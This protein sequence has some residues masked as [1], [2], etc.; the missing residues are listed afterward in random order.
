MDIKGKLVEPHNAANTVEQQRTSGERRR[1]RVKGDAEHA[2]A[3]ET[4]TVNLSLAKQ[5]NTQVVNERL[6]R[7]AE[8]KALVQAGNYKPDSKAVAA[9]VV[10]FIDDEIWFEKLHRANREG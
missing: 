6:Q 3:Q 4:D 8:L 1:I 9:S 5:I 7:V 10:G 2:S